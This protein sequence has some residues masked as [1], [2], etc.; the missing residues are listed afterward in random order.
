MHA[1]RS[2]RREQSGKELVLPAGKVELAAQRPTR[3]VPLDQVEGHMAKN[4]EIVGGVVVA[5]SNLVLF[6]HRIENP[7]QAVFDPQ[8][9]R[10]TSP[11]RS[12]MALLSR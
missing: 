5:V 8:C 3:A 4:R 2:C 12:G 10:T 11:S 1:A 7:V 9:E 6:H